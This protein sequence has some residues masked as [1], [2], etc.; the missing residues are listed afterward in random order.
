MLGAQILEM[1]SVGTPMETEDTGV[2]VEGSL[3]VLVA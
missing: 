2:A 3:V 1:P